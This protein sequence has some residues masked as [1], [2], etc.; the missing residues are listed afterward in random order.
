[1]KKTVRTTLS[2][3]A[4]P[5]S[6]KTIRA[7]ERTF[8]VMH[9]LRELKDASIAELEEKTALPR[10]TLLRILKT[11]MEMGAV[12]RGLKDRR[13]RNRVFLDDFTEQHTPSD[14][15]ADIAAP[16]LE[17]LCAV[18]HWPSTVGVYGDRDPGDYMQSIESTATI[19]PFYVSRL[20]KKRVN[21]L[22]SAQG[23][24]FLA[25]LDQSQLNLILEHIRHYS[26]DHHN[27]LAIASGDLEARLEQVRECG[28]ALRH[29]RYLG[30]A[31]NGAAADD[32]M[33]TMAVP[34]IADG[35]VFGAST[36]SWN[37]KAMTAQQAVENHLP[38]LQKTADAIAH[39]AQLRGIVPHFSL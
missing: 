25:Q 12:R 32:G 8:E 20:N 26:R 5:E 6:V 37:R 18:V 34:L 39:E 16:L 3:Q 28:Y 38:D 13:F 10:P 4:L 17:Q 35:R 15:L 14:R 24:A 22:M 31:Y 30:G 29:P 9:A 19:T 27:L 11:L 2:G 21:L 23:G 36:I 7:V 33:N 1:M